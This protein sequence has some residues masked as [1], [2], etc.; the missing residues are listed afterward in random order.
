MSIGQKLGVGNREATVFTS[1]PMQD[2]TLAIDGGEL[3]PTQVAEA[4]AALLDEAVPLS[5]KAAFLSALSDRG[6][7]PAEIGGFAAAFVERAVAPAL[8][9]AALGRPLLDVC[10][11]G[12][13]KLGLFNV[14]TGAVFV[15]AAAGAAVVKH[16]NRGITS[17]S[18]GAD[19]LEALGVRIDLAP[20][21]FG[22]CLESVGAGFLF[23]PLYHPA[24]KSVAPVRKQLGE[25]GRRTVFN[26]LGPL[27][28]PARP[29]CQLIGVFDPVIGPA[30]AEIL[31]RLGRKRAWVVHGRTET[32]AGM[33][34]VS[35]LG[36]TT[37]WSGPSDPVGFEI[38]PSSFGF[39]PARTQDLRGGDA[40]A[41]AAILL[42]ILEGRERGPRR[43][44]V[45][46]NA[47]AGLVVA[48]LT[49]G[50]S[51][52]LARAGEALDSGAALAVLERWRAFS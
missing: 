47:A 32:G 48:G 7:T 21:D 28:N 49:P 51:E 24:F 16:G 42:A 6:E 3:V 8:D 26:L 13:D 1:P 41:N 22:R 50:L 2:L 4:A 14:S 36:P 12:G 20:G 40:S 10:G 25:Q 27:L 30:F 39:S 17:P 52:G 43:D 11:T 45:A 44:L 33:D 34:E 38:E 23:A 46:L 31:P 29:D 9:R 19:V 15:L 35:T 5:E 18:G 37:V